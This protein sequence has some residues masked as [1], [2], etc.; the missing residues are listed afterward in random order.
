[1]KV[2]RVSTSTTRAGRRVP[3]QSGKWYGVFV[4][5]SGALR[6][7]PLLTDRKASDALAHAID[8]LNSLRAAGETIPPDLTRIVES[9]PPAVLGKLAGW[10][11]IPASRL[12]AAKPLTD[13]LADWHAALLAKGTTAKQANLVNGRARTIID[14]I[15]AGSFS[16]VT[17]EKVASYLADLRERLSQRTSN[18]YL[19]ALGGFLRWAVRERRIVENPIAHLG[20]VQVTDATVRRAL[21][22]DEQRWLLNVTERE[23]ARFGMSGPERALAYHLALTTGLRASELAALTVSSFDLRADP[24]TV[25]LPAAKTKNRRG[26][27]QPIPR[28]LAETLR[29]FLGLKA[30]GARALNLPSKHRTAAM[31]RADLTAARSAWLNHA[32]DPADRAEREQSEFLRHDGSAGR[33]DFHAL[34]HSFGTG[35]ALA[36]TPPKIA[37]DLMRHGT[38]GLTMDLY[39]HT[40]VADR[41]AALEA[42]LPDL[43]VPPAEAIV[44]T[45]TDQ[46][47]SRAGA[48]SPAL[49]PRG[50]FRRKSADVGGLCATNATGRETSKNPRETAENTELTS[51][52]PAGFEPATPGLGNRCSILLSYE[53][54]SGTHPGRLADRNV[55]RPHDARPRIAG[56]HPPGRKVPTSMLY[57]SAA[58]R[59]TP[60]QPHCAVPPGRLRGAATLGRSAPVRPRYD[61]WFDAPKSRGRPASGGSRRLLTRLWPDARR[62]L[63]CPPKRSVTHST[64][65][66]QED[67]ERA[68]DKLP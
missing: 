30:P 12:S 48:L 34:R 44:L 2:K 20:G 32:S 47:P 41:A 50:G 67:Y 23:P 53:R 16:N 55:H 21:S 18:F 8:R 58:L 11:I 35:L 6:R 57:L 61:S 64:L 59:S 68:E 54:P 66:V 9:M 39:S 22:A 33:I 46:R 45:G 10:G 43:T 31:L 27:C 42:A 28:G 37:M 62:P 65:T 19:V 40:V 29:R 49:S 56:L 51:P 63:Q 13:H 15:G 38:I 5:Y 4:D 17:G 3:R 26:A 36:G 7:L 52:R 1:M 25:S 60:Q 24:P 14:G